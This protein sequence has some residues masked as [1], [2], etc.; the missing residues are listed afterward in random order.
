MEQWSLNNIFKSEILVEYVM[1]SEILA[2]Y[3]HRLE[4]WEIA[5]AVVT[6]VIHMEQWSLNKI[7]KS[8]NL[9]Q[10]SEVKVWVN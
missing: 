3:V 9:L 10:I 5:L 1:L 2:E 8:E 7:F 6:A 4:L